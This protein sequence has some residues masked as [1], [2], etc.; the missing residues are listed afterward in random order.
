[1]LGLDTG[2]RHEGQDSPLAVVVGSHDDRQVLHADDEDQRPDEEREDAEDILP[3]HRHRVRSEEALLEGVE[4][5]RAMS[6]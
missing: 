3:G 5:A 4:R 2:Q 1:M 6:P